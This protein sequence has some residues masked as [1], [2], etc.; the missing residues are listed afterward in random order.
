MNKTIIFFLLI[1]VSISVNGQT[2]IDELININL[3]GNVTKLDTIIKDVPVKNFFS[4]INNETYL[5]Q[6]TKLDERNNELNNLP[7]DIESLRKSYNECI[8]GYTKSMKVN[9]YTFSN[10]S[11]FKRDK[12]LY[13]KASFNDSNESNKKVIEANFLILNEHTYIITY[14][15]NIDFNEKNKDDFMNSIKIDSSLNPSQTIGNSYAY[16]TGYIIGYLLLLGVIIFL[17]F[18]FKKKIT[19]G[20]SYKKVFRQ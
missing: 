2:K 19:A 1:V 4:Q 3:P 11:E 17:C 20:N 12:Y 14:L 5:I 9:G 7:S 8:K 13:F 15:N 16:K 6:K 10:S 18:K